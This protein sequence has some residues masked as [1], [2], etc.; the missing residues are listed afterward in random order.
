[1]SSPMLATSLPSG[2]ATTLRIHFEC[3]SIVRITSPEVM[4]HQTSLPS[5]PPEMRD[6]P[7][8]ATPVT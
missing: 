3:A 2:D 5:Y 1:M 6:R 4:S 8:T 7:A